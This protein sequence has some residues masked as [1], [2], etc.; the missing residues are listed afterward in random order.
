M[1]INSFFIVPLY[2]YC[3][4]YMVV[5]LSISEYLRQW[6]VHEQ[7]GQTPVRLNRGSIESALLRQFL[8]KAPDDYIPERAAD[9]DLAIVIPSFPEKDPRTYYYLPPK[10]HDALVSCIRTR[11]DLEMWKELYRFCNFFKRQDELIYAF[12]EKHGIEP[13]EQNFNAIAKR[14]QRKREAYKRR[15]DKNV[16]KRTEFNTSKAEDLDMSVF[17]SFAKSAK[18]EEVA[19]N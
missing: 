5:Y 3:L 17:E 4:I 9:G 6:F 7:G 10:A 1:K 15:S 19:D 16:K 8:R 18:N 12:M 14:Y 11:F 13:T 2:C